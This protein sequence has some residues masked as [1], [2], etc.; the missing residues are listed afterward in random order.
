MMLNDDGMVA[1]LLT[2]RAAHEALGRGEHPRRCNKTWWRYH[3]II[4]GVKALRM[5]D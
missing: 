2:L 3:D 1:N 5:M 4:Q